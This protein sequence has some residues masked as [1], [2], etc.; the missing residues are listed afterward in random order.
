MEAGRPC[1][2]VVGDRDFVS[3][4][5]AAAS[6]A[7]PLLPVDDG[8]LCCDMVAAQSGEAVYYICDVTHAA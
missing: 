5:F 2:R 7:A 1:E 6:G 4:G 8:L 3:L